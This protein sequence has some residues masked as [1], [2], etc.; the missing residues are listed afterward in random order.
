MKRRGCDA[1]IQL[2]NPTEAPEPMLWKRLI[3]SG[4]GVLG[5]FGDPLGSEHVE[6]FV[7]ASEEEADESIVIVRIGS[8]RYRGVRHAQVKQRDSPAIADMRFDLARVAN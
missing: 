7:A 8:G 4:R 1:C 2:M 3:A 5:I 6:R